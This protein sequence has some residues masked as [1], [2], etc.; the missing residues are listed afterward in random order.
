[1][2]STNIL[3]AKITL[4]TVPQYHVWTVKRT[5]FKV[6]L[7]EAEKSTFMEYGVPNM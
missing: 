6:V 1:M 7:I 3:V 2:Q 4:R 5:E